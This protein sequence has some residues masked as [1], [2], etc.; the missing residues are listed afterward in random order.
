MFA[1]PQ[2]LPK[3]KKILLAQY[4][5]YHGTWDGVLIRCLLGR[6]VLQIQCLHYCGVSS[7]IGCQLC[8]TALFTKPPFPKNH[9]PQHPPEAIPAGSSHWQPMDTFPFHRN[10]TSQN[11]GTAGNHE[12][13]SFVNSAIH[14]ATVQRSAGGWNDPQRLSQPLAPFT[15]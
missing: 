11:H 15:A 6:R 5:A 3:K 7:L 14:K 12:A 13:S 10:C 9:W 2:K 1:A 4:L 8:F